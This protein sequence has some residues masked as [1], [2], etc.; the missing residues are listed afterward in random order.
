MSL[1]ASSTSRLSV[2]LEPDAR[3][4]LAMID[5]LF[6]RLDG[7]YPH[8]WRSAFGSD[9]AI[10]NWREAWA[11][12]FVSECVTASEV[13]IGL[14]ACRT[15]FQWPPSFA[16][17]LLACRPAVDFEAAFYE[18]VTQLRKRE[19]GQDTWSHPAIFWASVA[20]GQYNL[21]NAVWS[22]MQSRWTVALKQEM[23]KGEWPE[24]PTPRLSLPEPGQTTS[25]EAATQA[26]SNIRAMMSARN[27]TAHT[28]TTCNA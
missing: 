3:L 9:M 4:G 15:R 20:I 7:L 11:D 27:A 6:N 28:T 21:R 26:L 25:K 23:E 17:F 5:H 14:H 18:A 1:P 19:T 13:K 10:A 16:E 24:I 8:R 2:W 12:G 22:A